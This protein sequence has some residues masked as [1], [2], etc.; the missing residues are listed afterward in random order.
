MRRLGAGSF[1]HVDLCEVR[2]PAPSFFAT[3]PPPDQYAVKVFNK[4]IL[5]KKRKYVADATGRMK[6]T[7]ELDKTAE[8]RLSRENSPRQ[9]CHHIFTPSSPHPTPTPP[10]R[11]QEIAI[12]K[13]LRHP[14]LV[15]LHD[16]VD[17]EEEDMLYL[18]IEYVPGGPLMDWDSDTCAYVSAKTNGPLGEKLADAATADVLHGLACVRLT[19]WPLSLSL[20]LLR[21]RV[22]AR[23]TVTCTFITS[24]TATSSRRT[25]RRVARVLRD[26]AS[27]LIRLPL[28]TWRSPR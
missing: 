8:V 9:R 17:D 2:H 11:P 21:R 14:N 10:R 13:R 19:S 7:T 6:F 15:N 18:V 25:V 24:A 3:A 22:D 27:A 1:A 23:D 20:S 26:S 12:M 28:P 16:A 5:R 4:S